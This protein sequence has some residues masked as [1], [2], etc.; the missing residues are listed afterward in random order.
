[1]PNLPEWFLARLTTPDRAAAILGDLT[2]MAA[3]RS[4]LWFVA[5]YARTLIT[6]GWRAPVALVVAITSISFMFPKLFPWLTNHRTH[7]RD[8]GLFGEYNLHVRFVTWN[9]SF[10]IAQALIFALPF[11]FVRYGRHNRLTQLTCALFLII[12]PVYTLRPWVIDLSGGLTLLAVI[13]A[14]LSRLWRKPMIVLA[15]TC[16]T[17]NAVRAT[18]FILINDAYRPK[19]LA[20]HSW[21]NA[22]NAVSFVLATIVCL[23]LHRTLLRQRQAI[24]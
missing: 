5:A 7:M 24:A 10:G 16:V 8:A 18:Y 1:M 6:L 17:A 4:R 14:L 13:A 2:E 23:Y 11:V 20:L 21:V 15:A 12:I 9:I 22:Y 3:T 19:V